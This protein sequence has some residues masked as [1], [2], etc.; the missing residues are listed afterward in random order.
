MPLTRHRADRPLLLVAVLAAVLMC[1]GCGTNAFDAASPA[2]VQVRVDS[3][4]MSALQTEFDGGHR[5]GLS[6]PVQVI[7]DFLEQDLALSGNKVADVQDKK[8]PNG[9]CD[10]TVTLQDGRTI[11]FVLVQPVRTGSTGIWCVQ[12]YRFLTKQ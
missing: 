11:Q 2:W 8:Q 3:A 12:K 4:T 10:V 7:S 5:V 9:Q 1:T 6:D